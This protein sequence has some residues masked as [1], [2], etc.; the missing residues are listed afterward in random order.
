MRYT[1]L[2]VLHDFAA[3][4]VVYLELRTTPRALHSPSGTLSKA[5]YV[6]T[7]L[8]AIRGFEA[9][10]GRLRTRLILSVDR[11]NSLAEALEVVELCR[12]FQPHGVVGIDLCGDPQR[13][14]IEALAP[15]FAS[16]R[17]IAG[18]GLT[19]HFAEVACSATDEELRLLLSW[20]P[21]RIGH[22]IHVGGEIRQ[23]IVDRGGMGLE[24][25]LSCNV[26]AKMVSGGFET[27]HFGD[28]WKVDGC[29]VVLCVSPATP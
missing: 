4:G 3:D 8:D 11:R 26:H 9:G 25:C 20:Q 17:K 23:A 14:G 1:T 12:A 29:V 28:W 5:Q 16:A 2:S 10:G 27:H 7:V 18:L 6:Q 24:L 15:A 13:A 19:L 22:V 21:D